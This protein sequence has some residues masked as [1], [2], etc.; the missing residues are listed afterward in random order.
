ML[1]LSERE[2]NSQGDHEAWTES[3]RGQWGGA[4]RKGQ[5]ETRHCHH[6]HLLRPGLVVSPSPPVAMA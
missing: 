3:I 5:G 6:G 1:V 2:K 4:A